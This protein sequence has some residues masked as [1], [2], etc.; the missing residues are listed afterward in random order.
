MKTIFV[1]DDSDANLIMAKR[2]LENNYYIRTMPSAITMLKLMGK[3]IPDLILLDIEMPD[4]DGFEAIRKL[5]ENELTAKIPVMFLTAETDDEI[6]AKGIALGAA[7]FI[8]KPFSAPVLLNRIAYHL[9]VDGLIK[10]RTE[11][12]KHMQNSMLSVIADMVESRDEVTG[13]HV[14]RTSQYVRILLEEM[15]NR[16][17]YSEEMQ[18]WD[19]ET[20]VSSAHLHDVGK[21]AVSDLI[22][23]KPAKLTPEEY[24]EIKKHALKGEQMIDKIIAK[25][26]EETF[27]HHAKL[28]AGYHHE[29]WDG[30]GYPEGLKST[31]IPLQGRIMAIADVYD[32]LVSE[33]PYKKPFTHEQ[34]VE[35]IKNDSGTHFDPEI[36][37]VFITVENLFKSVK[38]ELNKSEEVI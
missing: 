9:Q 17:I 29:K 24:E 2:A 22:L 35:I 25:T 30:K 33:R 14:E 16:N 34:A 18:N 19:F 7:D 12:L 38:T 11:R 5:K 3:I 28:F 31:N 10:N 27:L 21:I 15:L 8:S 26:G 20:V 6:E 4:M 1:V 13:S 37:E 23:N 32:A 36:I